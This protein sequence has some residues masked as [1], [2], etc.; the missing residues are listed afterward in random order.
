MTAHLLGLRAENFK[1]LTLVDVTFDAAGG[2]VAIMGENEAGKS[3]LLDALEVVIAGRKATKIAQP[4]HAGADSARVIAT[5]DDIVVT[6]TY[7]PNGTTQIEV[8]S[9]DG[10]RV[11]AAE[12]LLRSLYSHVALDPL[13]F[14][15][16][17][18]AE[19]VATLLPM[20]G[21]DPAPLDKERDETFDLRTDVNR[22][23]KALEARL[24]AFPDPDPRAPTEP[25][26]VTELTAQLEA[27]MRV[28]AERADLTWAIEQR[29]TTL[30]QN[31][32]EIERAEA[33][34][35]EL[36]AQNDK[37]GAEIAEKRRALATV[38]PV[39]IEPLREQ[40]ANAEQTNE[41]VRVQQQRALVADE[42]ASAR[43]H[44]DELTVKLGEIKSRRQA[45][46]AASKMPVPGLSIDDE[47]GVLTLN[48]VPFSQA[49]TGVK[50]RTGTAI[51]MSL[52]PDLRL[53]VI[54]DASLLD[55]GNRAVIDELARANGF[56]V[57]M[58]I[59]DETMPVGVVIEEG[60]VRETRS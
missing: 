25:V 21:F 37:I 38:A 57:L 3:S 23:V 49:S 46:L 16:L 13:A 15:R 30:S 19:Q 41:R 24:A 56:L 36:R 43:K 31:M 33:R 40:I 51:A 9:A 20:I 39:E 1:R 8:K 53:I 28:N 47:E 18:D 52:N 42:L 58:E 44:S 10:R 11:A 32:S 17:T 5:F 2:V 35:A 60:T 6:R 54:R 59:A 29:E 22:D 26:S 27:G 12:D 14:S 7:K 48:G 34:I 4:I 45:A 50:I 55:A